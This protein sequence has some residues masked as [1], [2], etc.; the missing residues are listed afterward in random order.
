MKQDSVATLKAKLWK[1]SYLNDDRVVKIQFKIAS[2]Y[3]QIFY[4][5]SV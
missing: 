5:W 4:L 2:S 3:M 1:S